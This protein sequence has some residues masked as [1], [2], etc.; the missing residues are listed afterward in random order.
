MTSVTLAP[1]AAETAA[2]PETHLVRRY[3]P[4]QQ[5]I[6]WIGVISFFLL[7]LTGVALLF[8]PLSFLAKGGTSGVIHRIGA[9]AFILLP[10]LYL[11]RMPRKAFELVRESFTYGR[12]ELAW[13]KHMP[14]YFLGSTRNLPPQGRLN[15]GQKLHHAATFLM[16]NTVTLS[17]L[18][19]WFGKGQLGPEGLSAVVIVH[20]IS[21]LG[22]SVM[23]I[24]HVYFTFLYGALSG[25]VTGKVSEEYARMEHSK[26][27]ESL[28]AETPAA[29]EKT[30]ARPAE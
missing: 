2:G 19:M 21:M 10:A 4:A 29:A 6:H 25:M 1:T 28:Q 23:M 3:V 27:Y 15:A 9:I 14:G 11:L 18:I 30:E 16:F 13:F 8:P 26:W 7:L 5:V 17:G 22:L 24:G 12:E 20:D